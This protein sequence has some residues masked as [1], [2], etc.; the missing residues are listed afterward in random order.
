MPRLT[1]NNHSSAV[2]RL[3]MSPISFCRP[4][5]PWLSAGLVRNGERHDRRVLVAA[6]RHR[7]VL[8][9]AIQVRQRRSRRLAG[10]LDLTQEIA[11]LL[12]EYVQVLPCEVGIAIGR[13]WRNQRHAPIAVAAP[14]A[15][16]QQRFRDERT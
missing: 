16:E 7:E 4:G 11:R 14:D 9:P 5:I 3:P 2:A 8:L 1:T 10:Q 13:P 6:Y 12:V 15:H